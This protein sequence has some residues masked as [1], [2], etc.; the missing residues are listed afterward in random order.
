[1]NKIC[2]NCNKDF[3]SQTKYINRAKRLNKSLFCSRKCRNESL[4]I[5]RVVK[6]CVK[7][8]KNFESLTSENRKFCSSSCSATFFNL[9]RT[10]TKLANCLNCNNQVNDK[11]CKFCSQK[12]FISYRINKKVNTGEA[13]SNTIK[14]F[15]LR[16]YGHHCFKCRNTQWNNIPITL[17][18]EHKD[19]NSENNSLENVELL[20]PNCHSQTSTYKS[21]NKGNGRFSRRKR[22]QEGL[23]Y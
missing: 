10:I 7:C 18:L 1:M 21:K 11:R 9:R 13:S 5:E 3:I 20:C 19:G 17:E 16:T 22:Y 23:S 6:L 15:L 4:R 14:K 2:P 12:C 8:E